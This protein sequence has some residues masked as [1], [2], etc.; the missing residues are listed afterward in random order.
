MVARSPCLFRKMTQ[1]PFSLFF[2]ILLGLLIFWQPLA[3]AQ[4]Q[5]VQ[6]ELKELR[7]LLTQQRETTPETAL[8]RKQNLR[9]DILA[10]PS[11][12]I[13]DPDFPGAWYLPGTTAAMKVGGYVDLSIVNSFDPMLQP[14]FQGDSNTLR[15]RRS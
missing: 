5:D 7:E 3:A 9:K 14:D 12:T 11:S 13:Y 8:E 6:A 15:Y 4:E 2:G 1:S 10:D